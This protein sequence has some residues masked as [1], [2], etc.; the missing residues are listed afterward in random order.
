ML[1]KA[2]VNIHQIQIMPNNPHN[3]SPLTLKTYKKVSLKSKVTY[4]VQRHQL[5]SLQIWIT[6]IVHKQLDVKQRNPFKPQLM[7]NLPH[8]ISHNNKC[9]FKHPPQHPELSVVC[10]LTIHLIFK[11]LKNLMINVAQP[12]VPTK[13]K[14]VGS[15][16]R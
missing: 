16:P 6:Y 11:L 2:F 3:R 7:F 8:R 9:L 10:L 5:V 12:N 4:Q 15:Q 14:F 13:L 1:C